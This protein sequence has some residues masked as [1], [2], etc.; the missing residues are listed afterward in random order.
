MSVAD[1]FASKDV[2]KTDPTVLA[3]LAHSFHVDLS[4]VNAHFVLL[5][6]PN[7]QLAYFGNPKII[8]PQG[9]QP[10]YVLGPGSLLNL[11]AQLDGA[12]SCDGIMNYNWTNTG[13]YG[14]L[15]PSSGAGGLLDNFTS[16]ESMT[17]YTARPN[18]IGID[19]ITVQFFPT[20]A[21]NAAAM[22]CTAADVN[23]Q[24][25]L[26]IVFDG[27][28]TSQN[29]YQSVG[30]VYT[31]GYSASMQWHASW[32]V[33]PTKSGNFYGLDLPGGSPGSGFEPALPGT[34]VTGTTSAYNTNPAA[35]YTCS[36][37]PVIN[38]SHSGVTTALPQSPFL[39]YGP[40]PPVGS[41]IVSLWVDTFGGDDFHL[42]DGGFAAAG[43]YGQNQPPFPSWDLPSE[44]GMFNIDVS[45]WVNQPDHSAQISIS[46]D[47]QTMPDDFVTDN[48]Q[49]HFNGTLTLT[50]QTVTKN[51]SSMVKKAANT[52]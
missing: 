21:A 5:E 11:R 47:F 1:A 35:P 43:T 26:H 32:D 19:N 23:T 48:G 9:T 24:Q 17:T 38:T 25:V 15:T 6:D 4:N 29:D 45:Q 51:T 3:S 44:I 39:G 12:E 8:S 52:R 13:N 41:P 22:A 50:S 40:N 31:S 16:D 37:P 36:G 49:T 10:S 20:L 46:G 2:P 27:Q 34:S 33:I 7:N 18:S 30:N 42:C 28:G 14:H